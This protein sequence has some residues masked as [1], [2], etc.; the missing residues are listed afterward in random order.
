VSERRDLRQRVRTPLNHIVGYTELLLDLAL[1]R[2]LEDFVQDLRRI[3][4][5]TDELE[6]TLGELLEPAAPPAPGRAAPAA[7]GGRV[8]IVDGDADN[9][10]LTRRLLVK[11]GYEVTLATGGA[12]ALA[13]VSA[14]P[15]DLVLL[16][17]HVPG[18]DGIEVCRRLKEDPQTVLIPV[19][20]MTS[21]GEVADRVRGIEA[22]ADAFLTRPPERR[23]LLARIHASLHRKRELDGELDRLRGTQA[24]LSR[25]VPQAVRLLAQASGAPGSEQVEKD[26][27]VLFVDVS[28][29]S[30]L[31]EEL[32]RGADALVD[33]FF[34]SYLDDIHAHDGEVT[35]TA[36]DRLMAVFLGAAHA[37]AAAGAARAILARTSDLNAS[38]DQPLAVHLGINSGLALIGPAKYEGASGSRWTYTALGPVVNLAARIADAAEAGVI[39]VGAET[40]RRLAGSFATEELPARPLK[41]VSGL[42]RLHRIV[43]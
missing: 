27:S 12:Q 36:G 6:A 17:V 29:Y 20:I 15:P 4:S 38:L 2:G 40:A 35:E 7:I 37:V 10:E 28:G 32:G 30:R 14:D 13:A 41:N 9:R 43:S 39:L 21:L 3:R 16:D 1:E 24:Y 31:G 18:L 22:G 34:S 11:E 25:F 33:R 23:E 8:L 19:V 5:A 42:V 26:L